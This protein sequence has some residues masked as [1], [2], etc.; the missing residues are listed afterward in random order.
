MSDSARFMFSAIIAIAVFCLLV[1]VFM[2]VADRAS[3]QRRFRWF[4]ASF[5]FGLS[6]V[7]FAGILSGTALNAD[8]EHSVI[9]ATYHS[10]WMGPEQGYAAA[11][12]LLL[13][14]TYAIV[15]GVRGASRKDAAP[16][17]T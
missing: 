1:V 16:R 2:I 12:L 3:D 6:L 17:N 9:A 8:R 13:A 11:I 15:L 10:G 4:T 5:A 14:G 7:V